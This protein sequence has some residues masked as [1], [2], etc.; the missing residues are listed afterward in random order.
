LEGSD[1]NTL[2]P[3]STAGPAALKPQAQSPSQAR[4]EEL[5]DLAN[6]LESTFLAEMLKSA[7][8]GKSRES[9]GGGAGEEQFSSFMV[10]AQ[11]DQMVRAG[12]IGLAESLFES[13]KESSK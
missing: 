12:G 9:M 3:N 4:D 6:E 5:R 1:V 10:K 11:A 8:V 2:D 13:L 7:G